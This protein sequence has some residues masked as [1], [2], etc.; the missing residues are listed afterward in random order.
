MNLV[1]VALVLLLLAFM[2]WA[3]R[4]GEAIREREKP[5]SAL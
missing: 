2:F 4:R 5:G 3:F 1:Y